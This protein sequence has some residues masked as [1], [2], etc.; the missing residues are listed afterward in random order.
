MLVAILQA[1]LLLPIFA[2]IPSS[3]F[4]AVTSII[5]VLVD[6]LSTNALIYIA[7]SGQAASSRLFISP[8]KEKKWDSNAIGAA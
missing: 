1:P 7:E 3:A 6:L 2:L 5:Y 8:R 4:A